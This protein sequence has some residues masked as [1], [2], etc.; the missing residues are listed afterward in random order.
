MRMTIKSILFFVNLFTLVEGTTINLAVSANVSYAIKPLVEAFEDLHTKIKVIEILGSSGKLTAQIKNGAPY[1]LF[2]SANMA[3]PRSLYE[4]GF[5]STK[6]LI[7]AQG[8]LAILSTKPR[9]YC[10]ELF[11]LKDPSIE[12]I[13][14]A[15]PKTAPYGIATV[16]ALKNE[17]LYITLKDKFVYGESISQTV[18]YTT[19][20]ADIGIIAKSALFSP[21]LSQYREAIDWYEVDSRLYTPIDQ[22][23]VILQQAKDNKS[24]KAFYDFM[25]SS[26]AQEILKAFGYKIP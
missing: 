5:A 9:N 16:E 24:V 22:G 26:Q 8:A 14:I 3:Y 17:R 4:E 23:M 25:Q 7:Y 12:K 1:H 21:K 6:P 10:A 15:N 2:L 18:I 11:V 20:V 19:R 13:A